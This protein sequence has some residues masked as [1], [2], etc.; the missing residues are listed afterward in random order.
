ML[1]GQEAGEMKTSLGMYADVILSPSQR[2]GPGPGWALNGKLI[3][4]QSRE[5]GTHII[6]EHCPQMS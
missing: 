4:Q 2:H 5:L 3:C 6:H 1:K